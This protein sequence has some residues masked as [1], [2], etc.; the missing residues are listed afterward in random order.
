MA[1]GQSGTMISAMTPTTRQNLRP[2]TRTATS[3][4]CRAAPKRR[5]LRF[6][7]ALFVLLRSDRRSH[8]WRNRGA[9]RHEPATAHRIG[10]AHERFGRRYPTS[11]GR[12]HPGLQSLAE[13]R[14]RRAH[15]HQRRR[16][17]SPRV[18]GTPGGRRSPG[19][20][21]PSSRRTDDS[22]RNLGSRVAGK[23]CAGERPLGSREG[24]D[25]RD[26]GVGILRDTVVRQRLVP[27]RHAPDRPGRTRSATFIE[28]AHAL[29]FSR[30]VH[31]STGRADLSL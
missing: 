24:R 14:E 1:S 15:G 4:S 17:R 19:E 26:A 16:I 8:A 30:S 10:G 5:K 27:K 28:G 22:A 20:G 6:R 7:E 29:H 12:R 21:R 9:S 13:H 2:P 23:L 25:H 31:L 18:G 11:A 3:P